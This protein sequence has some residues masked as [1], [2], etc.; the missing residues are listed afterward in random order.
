[1]K[2]VESYDKS[3][4]NIMGKFFLDMEFTNGNYYL[5]DIIEMALIAE[6]SGNA[7][8]SYIRIHYSIP[9][10]V[11]ELT[12]ITDITLAAIGCRFNDS[13]TA[14]VEQLQSATDPIIIAHGGYLHDFPILLA[15]CMKYN[16]NDFGILKDCLVIDS[17]RILKYDGY[18]RPGLDTL[19]RIGYKEKHSFGIGRC[20]YTKEGFY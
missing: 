12:N 15:N 1:M 10:R 6:E 19:S 14:L 8:H 2:P 7:F 11:K 20:L 17:V 16:F 5:T 3:I 13:T 18:Q 9:K 4:V